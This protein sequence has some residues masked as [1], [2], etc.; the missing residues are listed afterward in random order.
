MSALPMPPLKL[1]GLEPVSIGEG[2][3]F[4]N[5][6]DPLMLR[7]VWRARFESGLRDNPESDAAATYRREAAAVILAQFPPKPAA[8]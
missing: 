3:L 2:T 6:I 4:V 1:S 8:P 5:M 7:S